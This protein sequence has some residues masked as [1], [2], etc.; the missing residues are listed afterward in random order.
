MLVLK[1][2][3]VVRNVRHKLMH[4]NIKLNSGKRKW[5]IVKISTNTT[6]EIARF[7]INPD[8]VNFI[9]PIPRHV[10]K[11]GMVQF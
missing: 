10:I 6:F 4:E 2:M 11:G 3:L 7:T 9:K 5:C 1:L 8:F